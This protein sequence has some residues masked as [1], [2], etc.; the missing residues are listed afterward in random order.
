MPNSGRED[1]P[2]ENAA[3]INA[4]KCA[5]DLQRMKAGM[6]SL[7]SIAIA[8]LAGFGVA[9]IWPHPA[10][11]TPLATGSYLPAPRILPDFNLVDMHGHPF[12]TQNLLGH[13]SLLVFGYT[14]CTDYCPTTLAT[15][16][17]LHKR[18]RGNAI[19]EMPKVIFMSMDAKR[20][21]PEH[22]AMYVPY[23]DP[24]FVAVTAADQPTTESVARKLGVSVLIEPGPNGNYTVDHSTAIYVVQP[25]GKL[26]AILTGPFSLDAL[27][28]DIHQIVGTA[29]SAANDFSHHDHQLQSISATFRVRHV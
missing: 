22:L 20:D 2:V 27:Q 17:A 11:R 18:L 3:R 28:K 14:S 4:L 19:D 13:W 23:F 25:D 15:L 12:G 7:A 21:T 10:A 6:W 24:D 1:G 5:P 29:P 16:S 8:G 9:Q 26:A